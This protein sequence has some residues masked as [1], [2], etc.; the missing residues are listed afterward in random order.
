MPMLPGT[1]IEI[2][3]ADLRPI[4]LRYALFDFDGTIS[5]IRQGWQQVMA[6]LM[7][8]VLLETPQHE[9][10]DAIT[11][12]VKETIDRTTGQQ[13]IFQMMALADQVRERGGEPLEPLAYKRIYLDRLWKHIR[14]RVE[15]L[16][17]GEIARNQLLV[18]GSLE[19]LRLLEEQGVT[20]YLASGTDREAV[21]AEAEALG[22]AGYFG[23]GIHGALDDWKSYSKAMVIE[24][25]LSHHRGD[26]QELVT[27]GDG[28]V[29][30]ENTVDAGGVA[31][32]VATDEVNGGQVDPWKRERLI[33]AGAHVV[34]PD[35]A[36]AATLLRLLECGVGSLDQSSSA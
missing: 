2:V 15:G 36:E 14:A 33:R 23:G 31:V 17:S 28:Y 1:A 20:C 12:L 19:M 8:E 18:R 27:F 11:S 30:I 32:A 7:I 29:E 25:I 22:V 5:L 9:G 34:V 6:P 16:R 4:T 35:L 26:A 10:R 13:T 3:R 24:G 21:I